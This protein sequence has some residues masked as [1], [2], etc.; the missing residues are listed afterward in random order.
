MSYPVRFVD[1]AGTTLRGTSMADAQPVGE[2]TPT[3]GY[4]SN[5]SA[6]KSRRIYGR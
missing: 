6:L 4:N 5:Q 2:S 1:F 3:K